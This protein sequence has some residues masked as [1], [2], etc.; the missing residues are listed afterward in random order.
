LAGFPLERLH[1]LQTSSDTLV[2]KPDPKVFEPILHALARDGITTDILYVGDALM[3]YYAARDAGLSFIGVTTGSTDERQF[4]DAGAGQ[5][6]T[7]LSMLRDL[8]A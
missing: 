5:T 8:I 3:D 7:R 4:R 1:T 2:H 6:V